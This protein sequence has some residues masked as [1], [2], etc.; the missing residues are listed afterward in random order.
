MIR[1]IILGR[2]QYPK[3]VERH[4][5]RRAGEQDK[6]TPKSKRRVACRPND[7]SGC[8]NYAGEDDRR[9]HKEPC[10]MM[11]VGY[12]MCQ[13][14]EVEDAIS[15]FRPK[16]FERKEGHYHSG[17]YQRGRKKCCATSC[18]MHPPLT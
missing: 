5:I 13:N 7:L 18:Q 11:S 2:A 6:A 14:V 17:H 9:N 16:S 1:Q 4:K 12:G 8:I 15:K 10:G 3:T